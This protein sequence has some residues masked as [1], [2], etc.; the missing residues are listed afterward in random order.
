MACWESL[1][2]ASDLLV[3][4]VVLASDCK[5]V[6]DDIHKGIGGSYGNVNVIREINHRLVI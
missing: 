2:L 4:L 3:N 5:M 6:I 1:A